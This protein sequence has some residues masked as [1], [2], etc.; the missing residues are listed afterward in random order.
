MPAIGPERAYIY[1]ITHVAN[2]PWMLRNGLHC[3]T[4]DHLDPEFHTIGIP[5]LIRQRLDWTV[6]IDPGGTLGDYIPF[7]FTSR[8]PMLYKIKTGHEVPS[9][10][11]SDIVVVVAS[12]RRLEEEGFSFV[13]TDR[14][15]K[16]RTA[17]FSS[18]LNDLSWVDWAILKRSDF[19]YDVDDPGKKERYQAEALVHRHLPIDAIEGIIC[20][21]DSTTDYVRAEAEDA[22]IATSVATHGGYFF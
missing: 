9:V 2:V 14:H 22:G 11:M 3:S 4:S 6:P 21:N 17:R 13:F 16:L 8:T 1:R 15:A 18:D 12:L 20:S 19:A 10:P 7:Y 5:D